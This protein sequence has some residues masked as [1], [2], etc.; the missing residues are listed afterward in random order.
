MFYPKKVVMNIEG[1]NDPRCYSLEWTKEFNITINNI[2][3]ILIFKT[4]PLSFLIS[5][6][7]RKYK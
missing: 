4:S 6:L 3:I 7:F 2:D 1:Q 5:T